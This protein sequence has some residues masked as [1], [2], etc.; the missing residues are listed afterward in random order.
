MG[1]EGLDRAGRW[2][3]IM[4][5]GVKGSLLSFTMAFPSLLLVTMSD[6]LEDTPKLFLAKVCHYSQKN[7]CVVIQLISSTDGAM[8]MKILMSSMK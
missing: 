1:W 6:T 7:F 5:D 8:N 4:E 2:L 3:P